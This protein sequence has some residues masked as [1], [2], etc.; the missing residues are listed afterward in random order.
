LNGF[1]GDFRTHQTEPHS[2]VSGKLLGPL[3]M[4]WTAPTIGIANFRKWHK[5]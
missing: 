4:W 2:S 3:L 5:A 1:K